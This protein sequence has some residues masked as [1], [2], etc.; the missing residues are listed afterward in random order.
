M[1]CRWHATHITHD[2]A[3]RDRWRPLQRRPSLGR[4]T[5]IVH[6]GWQTS[7]L[8]RV[9]RGDYGEFPTLLAE[10]LSA[11]FKERK[12]CLCRHVETDADYTKQVKVTVITAEQ[13]SRKT[14]F[15]DII[16]MF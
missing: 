5:R 12:T 8:G 7:G 2:S 10:H 3:E 11:D 13:E 14:F 15:E 16:T 4:H 9:Q 6:R 1:V